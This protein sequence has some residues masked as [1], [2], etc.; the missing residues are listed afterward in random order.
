VPF[1]STEF[2][3]RVLT[4]L[5]SENADVGSSARRLLQRYVPIGPGQSATVDE[6]RAWHSANE[7]YLFALD[8][9][10]YRWYIDELAK[11]RKIPS[12]ELRGSQRA[13]RGREG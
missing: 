11:Q 9:G 4:Q 13:T 6:W 12:Q 7:A 5:N 8:G 2:F 3:D 10:D 1:D